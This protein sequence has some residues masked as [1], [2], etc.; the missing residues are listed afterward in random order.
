MEAD[1]GLKTV[2]KWMITFVVMLGVFMSVMDITIVNVALP[3]MMGTFSQTMSAITWVA[4]GYSIAAI[5]VASMTGWLSTL[6]GRRT[7]YLSA[8]ILFVIGSILSATAKTFPQMIAY[9]IIQGFGSG[10]VIPISQAILR[11]T[12]P[13]RQFA[14]AM[15]IF[16]MGVV[17]APAIGPVLGGWLVDSYGWPYIFYINIPFGIIAIWMVF[18]YVR[19]P[20]YLKRGI[21]KVDWV[22]IL[23]LTVGLTSLQVFLER[24]QAKNWFS[25]PFIVAWSLISAVSLI[26]LI[27]WELRVKEPIIDLSILRNKPFAIGSIVGGL[28]GIV[29]LGTTFILP[30][31]TQTLLGYSAFQ[32]GLTLFPRALAILIFMPVAGML[33]NRVDAKVLIILGIGVTYWSYGLLAHISLA[34]AFQDLVPILLL[35]GVG[36][37]FLFVP[38][39]TVS[40]MTIPNE[41]MTNATSFFTLMRRI[42]GNVGYAMTVTILE[43]RSQFH[44]SRLIGNISA[45]RGYFLHIYHII[46]GYFHK[47][48]FGPV[49]DRLAALSF[50]SHSVNRQATMLSYNDLS[51]IFMLMFIFIAIFVLFLPN[52]KGAIN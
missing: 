31:F 34:V 50:L 20:G 37:A 28:Y 5:I 43:R 1:N 44:Y 38:L 42:G 27:F 33:Y 29:L 2:N 6:I 7:L 12:F 21:K 15:A 16:G 26:A 14:M 40:L 39:S 32:S 19:D 18:R 36:M 17:L 41:K 11:E 4:T 45:S 24:G 52:S 30:Q 48:G 51:W 23:F 3:H 25:S 10:A 49:R 8:L 46:S 13:K 47:M 35:M 22:G 9:R